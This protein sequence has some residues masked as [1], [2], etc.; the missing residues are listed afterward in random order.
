VDA[1]VAISVTEAIGVTDAVAVRPPVVI[2]IGETIGVGDVVQ[3]RPPVKIAITEAV[4]VV[5]AV[6]VTG[7]APV[8]I[9]VAEAIGVV[10]TA[11]VRPPV[12]ISLTEA[13]GVGD[14]VSV[15]GPVTVESILAFLASLDDDDFRRGD[16][17]RRILERLITVAD[18]SADA[19]DAALA[20]VDGC[21]E[22]ADRNDLIVECQA[23]REVRRLLTLLREQLLNEE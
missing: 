10:D 4:G 22:V 23:Q 18:R 12:V 16:T 1:P 11:A 14:A 21:G 6:V 17:G 15:A 8:V 20:R 2:T 13:I 19:T 7:D 9:T 3:V 5:D